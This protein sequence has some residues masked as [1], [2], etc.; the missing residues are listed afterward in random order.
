MEHKE[1]REHLQRVLDDISS[2]RKVDLD[3]ALA[4]LI[5]L[6]LELEDEIAKLRARLSETRVES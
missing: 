2:Q 5:H 4:E 3:E 1:R 6:V